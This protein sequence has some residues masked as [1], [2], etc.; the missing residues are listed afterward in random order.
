MAQVYNP[1]LGPPPKA[2]APAEPA[3]APASTPAPEPKIAKKAWNDLDLPYPGT[4]EMLHSEVKCMPLRDCFKTMCVVGSL[5]LI[6]MWCLVFTLAKAKADWSS[7]FIVY[8]VSACYSMSCMC[9]FV[10][11]TV[12][13]Y[14]C[15]S[16]TRIILLYHMYLSMERRHRRDRR[17]DEAN[18]YVHTFIYIGGCVVYTVNWPVWN[19]EEIAIEVISDP[20]NIVSYLP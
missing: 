5:Y 7:L 9:A 11:Y 15:T 19:S 6:E 14:S 2:P 3:P 16:Y 10:K 1:L 17:L 18:T 12:C 8:H 4:F 20:H 13:L